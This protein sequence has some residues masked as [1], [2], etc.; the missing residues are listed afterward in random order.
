MQA[1]KQRILV[2]EALQQARLAVRPLP[3]P[4]PGDVVVRSLL[5]TFKHG[6]EMM[7]YSGR[8]PFAARTFD[9]HLRL[10]EAARQPTDFYPRPMGNMVVGTVEW[11]GS[12]VKGL[13]QGERVFA[14][15]PVAD[16]HV[17]AAE[18][19]RPLGGLEPQEALCIDPAHFALGAVIDGG[20]AAS[21]CVLVTGLGA[22]GLLAVQYCRL[23]GARVLASSSFPLRRRPAE[24]FGAAEVYD[25]RAHDDL[26]RHIKERTGGGVDA[27]IECSGSLGNLNLAIR[28]ARQ[29]GRV[30]CVG[31]YGPAD[32]R[33]NLGEEFFHNRLS[34]LASL[35]AHAWGNPVRGPTPLYAKDLQAAVTRDFEAGR[36]TPLGILDPIMPF[37]EADRAVRLI[38]EEPHRVVKVVLDHS[39]P[40]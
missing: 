12:E 8:S 7:V 33:L 30:V 15:A 37:S 27:A 24:A 4:G 5:S 9:P 21:D 14:W 2:M 17:L 18:R 32:S 25:L 1:G 31:F 13:E 16:V 26:A 35:P 10:F 20:I 36:I 39:A 29:C 22:V 34:L 28:S 11:A 38:A 40:D 19:V 6:T 23:Q 3:A